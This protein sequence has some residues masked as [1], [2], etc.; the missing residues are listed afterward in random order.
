VP[1]NQGYAMLAIY[2]GRLQGGLNCN[3]GAPR[4]SRIGGWQA[5]NLSP[6]QWWDLQRIWVAHDHHGMLPF[7]WCGKANPLQKRV[8]CTL[9]HSDDGWFIDHEVLPE[10]AVRE[11]IGKLNH[12]LSELGLAHVSVDV[13][14]GVQWSSFETEGKR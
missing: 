9:W 1:D 13:P 3:H 5:V 12:C 7:Y 4:P 10:V 8:F 11:R 6:E 14:D 2:A